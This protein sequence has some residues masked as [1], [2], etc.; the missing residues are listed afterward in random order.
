MNVLD[1]LIGIERA[2][3]ETEGDTIRVAA[4]L[5]ARRDSAVYK[6]HFPGMAVTPGVCM[7][8]AV[9]E[10]LA[11]ASGKKLKLQR[12]V[13]T[14]YL[15][16]MTPDDIDGATLSATLAPDGTATAAYTKAGTTYAKMK[17]VIS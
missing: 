3:V 11:G 14:K 17:L 7:V 9:V 5:K 6:G 16:M 8:G 10:L 12:V 15:S 1:E 2:A 4:T 13:N